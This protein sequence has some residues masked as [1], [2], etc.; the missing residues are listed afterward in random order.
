V[1]ILLRIDSA[2]EPLCSVFGC[3]HTYLFNVSVNG[4]EDYKECIH[5]FL[6]RL[7]SRVTEVSSHTEK[8]ANAGLDVS[9]GGD[10]AALTTEVER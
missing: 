8:S 1:N 3:D 6:L 5:C 9:V 4:K 2:T 10:G 7:P